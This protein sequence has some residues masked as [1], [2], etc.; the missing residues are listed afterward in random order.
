MYTWM[1]II[2]MEEDQVQVSNHTSV[3]C[4]TD[5]CVC[6][7]VCVVTPSDVYMDADNSIGGGL[8]AG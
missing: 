7:C 1:L 8:S 6:V 2:Q 4:V 3:V 5:L